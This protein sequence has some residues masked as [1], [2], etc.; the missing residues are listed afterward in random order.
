MKLRLLLGTLQLLCVF[1][2]QAQNFDND[3]ALWLKAQFGKKIGSGFEL[4]YSL[5]FRFNNNVSQLGQVANDVGLR[6]KVNKH[7]KFFL[8]YVLRESLLPP[9]YYRITHQ[10][11]T[12]LSAKTEFQRFTLKYRLRL[13]TR[14][15]EGELPEDVLWPES[16]IR[17]KFSLYYQIVKRTKIYMA[18]EIA[19]PLADPESLGYNR[20]R[21]YLGCEYQL[22][23][24]SSLEPYFMLQR[25]YS[26]NNQP[27]RDFI[28]GLNF[29]FK[30]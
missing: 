1:L 3:A 20:S 4:R 8:N 19:N 23:R 22:N 6:Y 27:R 7:L 18:Y 10:F 28:Y 13:Q 24:S 26:L 2:L 21:T 15:R 25:H 12:G 5:Q 9:G 30:F 17:N 11:Y 14:I 29:N 16:V